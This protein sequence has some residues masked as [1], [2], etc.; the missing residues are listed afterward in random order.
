MDVSTGVATLRIV[1]SFGI[2]P[3]HHAEPVYYAGAARS[4]DRFADDKIAQAKSHRLRFYL[5]TATSLKEGS[6][7]VE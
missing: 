7:R 1:W 4:L 5:F 3:T 2:K 6:P